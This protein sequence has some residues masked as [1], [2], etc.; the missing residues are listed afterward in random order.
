[1]EKGFKS[2]ISKLLQS[3]F[4]S[5][6]PNTISDVSDHRNNRRLIDLFSPVPQPQ[7]SSTSNRPKKQKLHLSSLGNTP[8][9]ANYVR[10][11]SHSVSPVPENPSKIDRKKKTHHRRRRNSASFSSIPDNH[12]YNWWSSDEDDQ[13][14]K[15]TLFS[16]RSN[17]LDFDESIR[18]NVVVVAKDSD[19]PYED[20]KAS[21]VDMIVEN[22]IF[23]VEELEKLVECFVSLNSEEHHKVI[24]DVFAEI[25][26]ILIAD[27]DD[28]KKE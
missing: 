25:W 28:K 14:S 1:M 10:R 13:K 15:T 20:F 27:S 17:S 16:R 26:E 7:P 24:F 8:F 22:E 21:M 19:D 2:Q 11:S 6:R 9:P 12:Y 5:C 3:T 4:N 18:E 23:G